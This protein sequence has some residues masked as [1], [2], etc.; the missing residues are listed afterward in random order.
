[1]K[2]LTW[3]LVPL[4]AY[5][6]FFV[7][8]VYVGLRRSQRQTTTSHFPKVTV[9]IAARNEERN[10]ADCVR[11]V[12]AQ[13]YPHDAL[14]VSVVDDASTDATPEIVRAIAAEDLRVS[15]L[16]LPE[17]PKDGIGG[18][19]DAIRAGVERTDS[20]IVMTTDADCFHSTSWV[21]TMVSYFG[22]ETALVAGP[23]TLAVAPS[24]FS[25][26][27]R[28]DFLGLV[29]SGAGLIGAGRPIICNG[30]NLAYRREVYLRALDGV[31]RSSNDDG[32]LMSRIVTRGLGGVAFASAADA[33]VTT[34]GQGDL[35]GFFRQ[36][37]RWAAVRGRF[38]DPTI[39]LE[40]VLLFAFFVIFVVTTFS[41]VVDRTYLPA[42]IGAW[43]IKVGA[44]LLP[45]LSA[46]RSWKIESRWAEILLAE[47][48]HP[49][50]IVI[51]S[52]LS[53]VAPFRWK[54][55]TLVR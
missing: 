9:I 40:L 14:K 38:L 5:Y 4:L 26:V 24:L 54:E 42:A 44:D 17:R 37:R 29:I 34:E 13:D 20:E 32:T 1:M 19:P 30:A 52:V 31:Q 7:I 35:G 18:K 33:L 36:R 16:T 3:A 11:S 22:P 10:I 2:V 51:A 43:S 8:R 41:A 6:V 46:A 21:R 49:F 28:L 55:R 15:L 47:I 27:E 45:L 50:S 53:V 23:V 48:F 39:Y 25:R 12:L